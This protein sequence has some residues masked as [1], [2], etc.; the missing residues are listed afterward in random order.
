M[1]KKIDKRE[2]TTHI[3]PGRSEK[4]MSAF[5]IDALEKTG[6]QA[7]VDFEEPEKLIIVETIGNRAGVGLI[8]RTMK[9]RYPFIRV[10]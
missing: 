7:Q 3:K 2:K 1:C 9:E 10:K 6:K 5:I 4:D 8:T